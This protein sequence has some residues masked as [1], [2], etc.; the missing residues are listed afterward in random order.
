MVWL[1][2]SCGVY[3]LGCLGFRFGC[4]IWTLYSKSGQRPG[5]LNRFVGLLLQLAG[6]VSCFGSPS[7]T[8]W[9]RQASSLRTETVRAAI[10]CI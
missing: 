3:S 8:A 4:G 10:L 2:R 9:W 5:R 7:V 6:V 1:V